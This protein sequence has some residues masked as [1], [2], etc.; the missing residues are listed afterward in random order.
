[1]I[2]IGI[3][4][5]GHMGRLHA[6]K[7]ARLAEEDDGVSFAGVADLALS[8]AQEVAAPLGAASFDGAAPL[9]RH[10]TA[11]I[12]AVPTVEH[13]AIV[14]A[15]FDTGCDVLVEKP[16]AAT[17]EEGEALLARAAREKRVLEVGHL[18][19]FNAA[20]QA[21][22]DQITQPRFVEAHR[23]GPFPDRA[24]DID[25]VRDLMIHDLDL[26]QQLLG[27]V[28]ERIEAIG[29]PVLSGNVDIA[30]A[31]LTYP[32]GCVAN[33]T[34]SRVS[35]TPMRKLRFFQKDGYFSIDFL[36]QSAVI[37]RRGGGDGEEKSIQMEKLDVDPSDALWTQLRRFVDSLRSRE[38]PLRGAHGNGA[39]GALRT[40]LR[41]VDAMP[42]FDELS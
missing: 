34:A 40:A 32:G 21:I 2:R 18:E 16:L 4:G 9:L 1:M 23:M 25:V 8:R 36:E 41:V 28:P 15:A 27:E 10:C 42:S 29:V 22:R 14:S 20:M 31:R 33:L 24:T 7:V 12:V 11:V 39:L 26:L 38:V 6:D 3:V 35:P 30:N 17:V 37:F 5:A 19:R 13:A